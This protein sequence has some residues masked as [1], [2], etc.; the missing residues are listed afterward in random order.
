[1]ESAPALSEDPVAASL[2]LIA[3]H[4]LSVQLAAVGGDMRALRERHLAA[5]V[6]NA[7]GQH[8]TTTVVSTVIP[9]RD[10]PS[11][12]RSATDFVVDWPP[13]SRRF[14]HVGELK[15]C[16]LGDDKVY[17]VIWDLFKMAL[18]TRIAGVR[19]AHLVTGAPAAMWPTAL[20]ADIF[21]GGTFDPEEL[22]RRRFPRGSRRT[23]WD[24]LLGGGYDRHRDR[25][26]RCVATTQVQEPVELRGPGGMWSCGRSASRSTSRLRTFRSPVGGPTVCVPQTLGIHRCGRDPRE[27]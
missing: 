8:L 16:Q 23:A 25:V 7:L 6:H 14:R 15:W 13:Q 12:G 2:P 10:W 18:M 19:T 3:K 21:H 4:L 22:C 20:C 5:A 1:V 27:T 11:L 17:E 26:P 9:L 24:H